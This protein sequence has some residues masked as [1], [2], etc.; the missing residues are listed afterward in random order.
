MEYLKDQVMSLVRCQMFLSFWIG[1]L[2]RKW[3]HAEVT[4]GS[5]GNDAYSTSGISQRLVFSRPV[6]TTSE[7]D[8]AL[9]MH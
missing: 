9:Y 1:I 2:E 3:G 6:K 8:V 7:P 4:N 5:S